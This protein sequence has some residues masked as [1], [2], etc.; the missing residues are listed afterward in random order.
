MPE[1]VWLYDNGHG[2]R[3]WSDVPPEDKDEA[4]KALI[5]TPARERV[6]E[7]KE[8]LQILNSAGASF[9]GGTDVYGVKKFIKVRITEENE[10]AI[11]F[12]LATIKQE[13]SE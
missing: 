12:L 3:W 10:E 6:E 5:A 2:H 7:I 9:D 8:L 1:N 11:K 13:E 4:V